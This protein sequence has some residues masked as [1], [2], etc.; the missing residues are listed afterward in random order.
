MQSLKPLAEPDGVIRALIVDDQPI[1][2]PGIRHLL[3]GKDR[4]D[5]EGEAASIEQAGERL[6]PHRA[7]VGLL[8]HN[9]PGINFVEGLPALLATRNRVQSA[10]LARDLGPGEPQSRTSHL[11]VISRRTTPCSPLPAIP[12]P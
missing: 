7:D 4:I 6:G 2:R 3:E 10:L 5:P 11:P 9:Q 1:F 8:D 12:T